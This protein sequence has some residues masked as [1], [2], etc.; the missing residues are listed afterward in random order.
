MDLNFELENA[1]VWPFGK[2]FA[3]LEMGWSRK[4]NFSTAT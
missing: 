1:P 4:E 2:V 3:C